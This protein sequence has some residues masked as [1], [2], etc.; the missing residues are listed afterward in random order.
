MQDE[1][2]SAPECRIL[3]PPGR[4]AV[5]VLQLQLS[6]ADAQSVLTDC[7]VTTISVAPHSAPVGR[8]LF[9]RWHGEDV[10][11]VRTAASV[12]EVHCHG[13]PAPVAAIVQSVRSRLPSL[14]SARHGA[15]T[16]GFSEL[17]ELEAEILGT[18]LQTRTQRTAAL[19]LNQYHGRLRQALSQLLMHRDDHVNARRH[20]ERLTA[21]QRLAARLTVPWRVLVAGPPNAGK[22]SLV[23]AVL[24]YE[25][26]LVFDQPGTTRDLVEADTVIDGWP[27]V[28]CDTAGLRKETDDPLERAGMALAQRAASACDALLIV[29]DATDVGDLPAILP[30]MPGIPTVQVHN[31]ADL[32]PGGELLATCPQPAD[33]SPPGPILITSALT[34][35]GIPELMQWLV[36]ALIP[37]EPSADTPVPVGNQVRAIL[38]GL[39]RDL[40]ANRSNSLYWQQ[41]EQLLSPEQTS[42]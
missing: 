24:G 31:K 3:T 42:L 7:F 39:E 14:M 10:V 23:N 15:D 8:I 35:A 41:L 6:A 32:L 1:K 22:S 29:A 33:T 12:W 40:S 2:S 34:G 28:F 26:A 20:V 19:V 11:L 37:A 5:A 30:E 36:R 13:G 16:R 38:S 17:P 9:G 27:F 25:R 21:W 18:L 4:A